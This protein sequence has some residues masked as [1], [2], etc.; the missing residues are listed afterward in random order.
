MDEVA[1]QIRSEFAHQAD[2][3]ARAPVYRLPQTLD[4]LLDLLPLRPDQRWCDVACG[5]GILTRALAPRVREAVGI[6]LTPAMLDRARRDAKGVAKVRFQL[7]D[8]TALPVPDGS[9]DGAVTR[10]ALHHIP[11]P[12]RVVREMSRAIRPGGY[13]AIADHL[14]VED[15]VGMAWHQ[16]IERL[17]DPSHWLC[18]T[19]GTLRALGQAAGLERIEERV[20]PF[21]LDFEEWLS[22]GS[23][24]PA[25]RALVEELLGAAPPGTAEVFGVAEGRLHVLLG[26]ALW[27]RS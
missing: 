25:H 3:F 9:F 15:P 8:A 4:A 11:A 13:L 23:T 21:S 1:S 5:P 16:T 18:L 24:G 2:A 12:A 22:R 27:K 10:F 6:D 26:I 7:G 19:P 20:I 14:T 17:R